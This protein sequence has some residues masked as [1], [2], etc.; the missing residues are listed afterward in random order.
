MGSDCRDTRGDC[1]KSV[2]LNQLK[3]RRT[4]IQIQLE[5][6]WAII[7]VGSGYKTFG[8]TYRSVALRGLARLQDHP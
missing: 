4:A 8:T 3:V 2:G 7:W 6:F 5:L 1:P